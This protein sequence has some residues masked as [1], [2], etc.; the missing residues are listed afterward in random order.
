VFS[1]LSAC[2]IQQRSLPLLFLTRFLERQSPHSR[3]RGG[4]IGHT[5]N[6]FASSSAAFTSLLLAQ[7]DHR[8]RM[9]FPLQ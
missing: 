3:R 6:N 5:L 1:K 2:G 4:D 9:F 8:I 7:G